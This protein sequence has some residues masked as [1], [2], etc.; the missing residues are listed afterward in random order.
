MSPPAAFSP[1]R[2]E[3]NRFLVPLGGSKDLIGFGLPVSLLVLD[4]ANG[5]YGSIHASPILLLLTERDHLR[6][7]LG[8]GRHLEVLEGS[9]DAGRVVGG[10]N[11]FLQLGP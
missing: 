9:V 11:G 2:G 10:L 1:I 4:E 7:A 3:E 6:V 5:D 8:E